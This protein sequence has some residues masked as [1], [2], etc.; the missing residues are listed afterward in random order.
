MTFDVAELERQ[1]A[2]DDRRWRDQVRRYESQEAQINLAI[3][4]AVLQYEVAL[5]TCWALALRP[6]HNTSQDPAQ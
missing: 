4:F 5:R 6:S 1:V 2:E 3:K